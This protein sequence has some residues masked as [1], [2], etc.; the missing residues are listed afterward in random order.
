MSIEPDDRSTRVFT[1]TPVASSVIKT[2]AT[3][4]AYRA[5]A[6]SNCIGSTTTTVVAG[7]FAR[8]QSTCFSR[9]TGSDA[10]TP[11]LNAAARKRTQSASSGFD[12]GGPGAAEPA[13]P[14]VTEPIRPVTGEP[15]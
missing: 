2:S 1:T 6:A 10:S 15:G 13:T 8:A 12:G 4:L 14:T 3:A 9:T 7:I 11:A 5:R